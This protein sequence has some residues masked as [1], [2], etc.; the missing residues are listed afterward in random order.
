M[1]ILIDEKGDRHIC[2]DCGQDGIKHWSDNRKF[3]G[4]YGR[5]FVQAKLTS[6]TW[7]ISKMP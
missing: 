5:Y 4:W 2:E 1:F 3:E 7:D 6:Q